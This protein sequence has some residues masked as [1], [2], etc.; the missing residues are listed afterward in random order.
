MT[1][2][3]QP[4]LNSVNNCCP[5]KFS[6]HNNTLFLS[7]LIQITNRCEVNKIKINGNC[8]RL[9]VLDLRS[10]Y[11]NGSMLLMKAIIER[12]ISDLYPFKTMYSRLMVA[13]VYSIYNYKPANHTVKILLI[14][15]LICIISF[16]TLFSIVLWEV[17]YD[18]W[19]NI[20]G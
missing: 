18:E 19:W 20:N 10:R 1:F 9:Q 4:L 11:S 14:E 12:S 8:Y 3:S 16:E 6:Y 2:R 17:L 5:S 13:V 7:I 15:L